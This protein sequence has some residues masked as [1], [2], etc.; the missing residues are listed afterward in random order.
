MSDM[1][2]TRRKPQRLS[3]DYLINPEQ[4]SGDAPEQCTRWVISVKAEQHLP[5]AILF[6]GVRGDLVLSVGSRVLFDII[7]ESPGV[8]FVARAFVLQNLPIFGYN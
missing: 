3:K 2:G 5:V 6:V 1:L 4:Q 7:L 8:L